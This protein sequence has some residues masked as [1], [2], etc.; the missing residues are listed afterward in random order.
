MGKTYDALRRASR[1]REEHVWPA[2]EV[3]REAPERRK[4]R[5][6]FWHRPVEP[7]NGPDT[8]PPP[9]LEHLAAVADRVASL[10]ERLASKFGQLEGRVLH[11]VET[12]L[13]HLED[14][15]ADVLRKIPTD[16]V[17]RLD[18]VDARLK[19]LSW[20]GAALMALLA[21]RLFVS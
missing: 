19:R 12:H 18:R 16:V 6:W 14:R 11:V 4:R 15:V 17:H 10:E 9:Y 5:G 1:D 7:P 13:L 3:R 21:L 8:D 2:A 20:I